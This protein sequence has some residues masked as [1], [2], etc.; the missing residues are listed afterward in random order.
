MK[1]IIPFINFQVNNELRNRSNNNSNFNSNNV[2]QRQ[3]TSNQPTINLSNQNN[4]QNAVPL[5][6]S[7]SQ[8]KHFVHYAKI[9]FTWPWKLVIGMLIAPVW[10]KIWNNKS[11]DDQV[12]DKAEE[13]VAKLSEEQKAKVRKIS[14]LLAIF[15]LY[16]EI[17]VIQFCTNPIKYNNILN[18]SVFSESF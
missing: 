16:F 15:C 9:L 11:Q 5:V 13:R 12:K 1:F 2:R 6:S 14:I 3:R 10:K 18:L 7:P 17:L 4:T 8:D